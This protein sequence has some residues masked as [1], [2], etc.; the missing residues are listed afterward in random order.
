MQDGPRRMVT[1][2]LT[3]ADIARGDHSMPRIDRN[4]ATTAAPE[5]IAR[6]V[7][8]LNTWRMTNYSPPSAASPL[9][10]SSFRSANKAGRNDP[11]PCGSGKKY[12]KCCGLN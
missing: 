2:M 7:V 11:C 4:A 3:L 10:P 5:N 9:P 12:K 8:T 1:G 6:W